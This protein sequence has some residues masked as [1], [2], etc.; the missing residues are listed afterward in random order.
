MISLIWKCSLDVQGRL[1]SYNYQYDHRRVLKLTATPHIY[2][3]I[4]SR[5]MKIAG[6][7]HIFCI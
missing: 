6:G 2:F 5:D 4:L 3:G 1:T 7:W